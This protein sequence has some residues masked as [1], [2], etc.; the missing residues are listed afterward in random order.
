MSN[1]DLNDLKLNL[2]EHKPVVKGQTLPIWRWLSVVIILAIVIFGGLLFYRRYAQKPI[3]IVETMTV[4]ENKSQ[5]GSIAFSAGGWVESVFPW[6][7]TVSA[8]IGGR[9]EELLVHEGVSVKKGQVIATL[10]KKDLEYELK[11]AEAELAIKQANLDR[12]E[13]GYRAEEIAQAKSEYERS[14]ALEEVKKQVF[15]RSKPLF[16]SGAISKEQLE[17]DESEYKIAKANREIAEQNYNLLKSGYR[18]QDIELARSEVEQ[19]KSLKNLAE[20]QLAYTD[21][22]SPEDGKIL[23]VFVTQGSFVMPEKPGIASIYDPTQIQVRVDV[24]Q[25]DLAKVTLGQ[26][27]KIIT[28]AQKD[29]PYEGTVIRIDPQ[30]NFAKD[31]IQVKVQ[32]KNPDDFL[33]PEMT[34]TV[35]FEIAG[36]EE[37][38]AAGTQKTPRLFV[39]RNAVISEGNKQYVFVARNS[40]AYK[41]PIVTGG[42]VMDKIEAVSGLAGGERVIINNIEKLSDGEEVAIKK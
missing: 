27:V 36:N 39:P 15:E 20:S 6:P 18:Q 37:S 23:E 13:A 8:L 17:N 34:A 2:P 21:I 32:V 4:A 10:Y 14:L 41:I 5:G 42:L 40:R 3:T 31:T 38:S 35:N 1:I 24:R 7:V 29:K 9:I 19:A 22:K 26:N 30:A 28:D 16:E 25:S 11:K 12:F 33:H